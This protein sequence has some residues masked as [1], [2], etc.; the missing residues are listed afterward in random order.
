MDKKKISGIISFVGMLIYCLLFV[1]ILIDEILNSSDYP[2]N[3]LFQVLIAIF[4]VSNVLYLIVTRF[5]VSAKPVEFKLLE[6]ENIILEK[7]IEQKEL[8]R[9]LE[10][11]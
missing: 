11:N 2:D 1:G 3:Y 7:K 9:K 10:E 5:W 4:F 6:K 8:K